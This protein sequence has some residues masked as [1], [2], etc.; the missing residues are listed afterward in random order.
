VRRIL[1]HG[2]PMIRDRWDEAKPHI[3]ALHLRKRSPRCQSSHILSD[4]PRDM[5]LVGLKVV[6]LQISLDVALG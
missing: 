3:I 1:C 4:Q 5:R 6:M 2:L